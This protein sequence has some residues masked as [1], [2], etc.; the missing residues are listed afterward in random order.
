MSDDPIRGTEVPII[1]NGR[2]ARA[3]V[4]R[5]LAEAEFNVSPRTVAKCAT[6]VAELGFGAE[7]M[8]GD[9]EVLGRLLLRS[10]GVSSSFIEGIRAPIIDV[11]LAEQDLVDEN[12]SAAWVAACL[13]ATEAAFKHVGPL[14]EQVLL[15][16]HRT[17][18]TGS[19]LPAR[20]VGVIRT[21]QGWIGGNDPTDAHLVTAPPQFLPELIADL[22][23]FANRDDIDP[24][25]Q[26]AIMHGQFEVIHPFGD[27]NG[28]LGR[29]L[30]GWLLCRRLSLSVAPPF[31]FS[32]AA[33][34]GAYGAG[35]V[36]YRMGN[37]DQWIQWF[38]SAIQKAARVQRN[39]IDELQVIKS[40]WLHALSEGSP[41]LRRD[42]L[43]WQLLE[44]LPRKL[45]LTSSMVENE[46]GVSKKAALDSLRELV[47]RGVLVEHGGLSSGHG[48]PAILFVSSDLLGLAGSNPLG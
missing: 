26:A 5:L 44:L 42:S 36:L 31:S 7:G 9:L 13:A 23:K 28:R 16:W 8:V 34:S 41:K 20:F 11:V 37:L 14:T 6:A 39:L 47:S 27:G 24:I 33:E 3:F 30:V 38:A 2:R 25:V 4:P 29:I 22:I 1:W 46:L 32:F 15:D 48:K 18:M 19:P 40:N 12:N 35:L 10:E 43:A 17:L 21:E 45:V